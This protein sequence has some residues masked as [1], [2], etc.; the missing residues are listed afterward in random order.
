MQL[1]IA[2]ASALV[3]GITA[4]ALQD[5]NLTPASSAPAY[6]PTNAAPPA[7][8]GSASELSGPTWQWQRTQAADGKLVAAAAPERYTLRFEAGGRVL[9]QADCNRG[10]G[11]YE[12][13]GGSMKMGPAML[14]R[15]ACPPDSQDSLFAAA[16]AGVTRYAINGDDLT[17]T[18]A[19][20]ATMRFRAKR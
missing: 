3:L 2:V 19:G 7:F 11:S 20:G 6:V 4:C 10:S 17:L 13:S 12:V 1:R 15:M 18:L 8:G 9:L 5:P 16:L 14:T